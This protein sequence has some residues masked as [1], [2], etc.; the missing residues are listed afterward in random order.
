[1]TFINFKISSLKI[2]RSKIF[3]IFYILRFFIKKFV[4]FVYVKYKGMMNEVLTKHGFKFDTINKEWC[5]KNWT[6]RID[7]DNIEV[8]DTTITDSGWLYYYG[9]KEKLDAILEDINIITRRR[10]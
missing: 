3:Y 9:E 4:T 7:G 6:V 8:F 2:N 5:K 1:L 10:F